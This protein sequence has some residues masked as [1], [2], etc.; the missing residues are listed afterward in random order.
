MMRGSL[1]RGSAK[2]K[3]AHMFS[4]TRAVNVLAAARM[5]ALRRPRRLVRRRPSR[6]PPHAGG[7]ELL[8][9]RRLPRR[10]GHL[11]R[12]RAGLRAVAPA[13]ARPR[14]ADRAHRDLARVHPRRAH[15]RRS[16]WRSQSDVDPS[17]VLVVGLLVFGVDLR[18]QLRG[19]LVPDPA[20]RRGRQGRDERRLLLHGERRRPPRRHR[21]L[22]RCSTSG[23]ASPRA[24]SPASSS[25]SPPGCS[26]CCSRAGRRSARH[27]RRVDSLRHDASMLSTGRHRPA[28]A[29]ADEQAV[30]GR[31]STARPLPAALDRAS[32]WSAGSRSAR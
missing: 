11:L 21:A 28:L 25:S 3:F 16:R 5:A 19:A 15:R 18:A 20:L 10:L 30:L 22:G 32:R 29:A 4:N 12:D 31:L 2:A 27:A 23:R 24:S 6:L 9:G 7:L 13:P 17:V 26:R 14:R 1:G 8:A